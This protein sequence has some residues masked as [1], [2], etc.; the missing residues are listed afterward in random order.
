MTQPA[1]L[2]VIYQR[3]DVIVTSMQRFCGFLAAETILT[4]LILKM[5][6]C[7]QY[8]SN[9]TLGI[10]RLETVPLVL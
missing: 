3:G 7:K 1:F 8:T 5:S 10:C 4:C 6:K 9:I 2:N